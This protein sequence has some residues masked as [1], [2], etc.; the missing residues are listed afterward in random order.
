MVSGESSKELRFFDQ[1]NDI[2]LSNWFKRPGIYI[3]VGG[4]PLECARNKL[5]QTS[6]TPVRC[7]QD[8]SR[9]AFTVP[10]SMPPFLSAF[11]LH[12]K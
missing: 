9:V 12:H 2:Q 11:S 6:L 3:L 8:L 1:N 7:S 10:V 4:E 5:R